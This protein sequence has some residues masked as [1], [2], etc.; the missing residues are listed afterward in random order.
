MNAKRKRT[1]RAAVTIAAGLV[2]MLLPT[3]CQAEAPAP[4]IGAQGSP[5]TAI[6]SPAVD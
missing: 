4:E 2:A 6:T 5:D 1:L 3:G